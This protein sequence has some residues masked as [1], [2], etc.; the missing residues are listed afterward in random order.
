MIMLRFFV[1]ALLLLASLG[2][3]AAAAEW[4]QVPTGTAQRQF[5]AV[6]LA[7]P[8]P[9]LLFAA[10]PE[11]VYESADDGGTW[12]LR[13]Q[14]PAGT[15]VRTLAV[16]PTQPPGLLVGT[17]RGLYGSWPD[18]TDWTVLSL[19]G[20]GA[21]ARCLRLVRAPQ[22]VE[23]WLG[24]ESGLWRSQ[25][26]GHTWAHVE[27]PFNGQ[28]V[29][30]VAVDAVRADQVYVLTAE[31]LFVRDLASGAWSEQFRQL[32]PDATSEAAIESAGEDGVAALIRPA[33]R[34]VAAHP[35]HGS[36]VYLATTR[37][38]FLSR[39]AGRDW[40][41]LAQ[42]GLP[43]LETARLLLQ[44]HSPLALYAA[45]TQGVAHYA[46]RPARWQVLAQGLG[47]AMVHDLA[48]SAQTLWAATDQG[49]FRFEISPEGWEPSEL[50]TPRE[51]LA[52]FPQE[53]A[54]GEVQ[55][56]VIRYA[57]VHPEKI[58][59]WRRQAAL[60]ALLPTLSLGVDH[61][62]SRD[63]H[64]DEGAY[65]NFQLFETTDRNAA[66]DVSINWDF[67]ELVWNDDQTSIDTRAKLM[68]ELREELVD[69]ATRTYFERRRLQTR[70]LLQ[71]PQEPQ[72]AVEQ[73]LRIAEL[74]ALI[75]GLTGGYFSA[76][77]AHTPTTPEGL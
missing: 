32:A 38:V 52:D 19:R 50:P 43:A 27:G 23:I 39:S 74:T 28:A 24:T 17:D 71:P 61:D 60:Q 37:G 75:D 44:A 55:A 58:R 56:A 20:K 76:A 6:A 41:R 53:P 1:W 42:T 11:A 31:R 47:A 49:L 45:T 4:Q 72:A 40:Q 57:E 73:E 10:T 34:A 2:S 7:A 3:H 67:G 65:P 16:L 59:R 25:D 5:I 36:V 64:V 29:L 8:Q 14:A 70:L 21:E 62:R 18:A 68:V 46:A 30:D 15:Q 13:W 63:V 9:G 26:E 12:R 35:Q 66:L 48:G 54:I 33:L 22:G 77:S 51:L 69:Q